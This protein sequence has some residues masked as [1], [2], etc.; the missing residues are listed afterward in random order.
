LATLGITSVVVVHLLVTLPLSHWPRI[1]GTAAPLATAIV[2][3]FIWRRSPRIVAHL[4]GLA[5]AVVTAFAAYWFVPTTAGISRWSTDQQVA[6]LEATPARDLTEL[7]RRRGL[8]Q[9]A[10]IE[11]AGPQPRI[12]AALVGWL[13]RSTDA[14]LSEVEALKREER[15]ADAEARIDDMGGIFEQVQP[16]IGFGRGDVLAL[17]RR[18]AQARLEL[19]QDELAALDRAGTDD[20]KIAALANRVRLGLGRYLDKEKLASFLSDCTRMAVRGDVRAVDQLFG[21]NKLDEAVRRL[22]RIPHDRVALLGFVN[23]LDQVPEY[24]ACLRGLVKA[25]LKAANERR[26]VCEGQERYDD[27]EQL[28][29]QL[30]AEWRGGPPDVWYLVELFVEGCHLVCMKAAIRQ[31]DSLVATGQFDAASAC[32]KA[33]REKRAADLQRE[34]TMPEGKRPLSTLLAAARQRLAQTGLKSYRKQFVA[35]VA[36]DKYDKVA[37]LVSDL[38]KE[39]WRDD[40]RACGID[41][42]VRAFV[43]GCDFVLAVARSAGKLPLDR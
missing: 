43:G 41:D 9:R 28:A 11:F 31:A 32:L 34:Q 21:Q 36:E 22:K 26:V 8:A 39:N 1:L 16:A 38:Q 40:A 6:A 42:Q 19:A 18:L 35:L 23:D 33:E 4:V 29:R 24:A 2:L 13:S 15:F 17:Q 30:E 5:V 25:R 7:Q 14:C 37:L 12:D 10:T 20:G 27:I 3:G